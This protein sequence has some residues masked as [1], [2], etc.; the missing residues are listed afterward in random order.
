MQLRLWPSYIVQGTEPLTRSFHLSE[1]WRRYSFTILPPPDPWDACFPEIVLDATAEGATCL[2]AVQ[3]EPGAEATPFRP[4]EPLEA[5]LITDQPAN[6]FLE[7]ESLKLHLGLYA[8]APTDVGR[9]ELRLVDYRGAKV[10]SQPIIVRRIPAGRHQRVLRPALRRTGAFRAELWQGDTLLEEAIL[11]VAPEPR[12]DVTLQTTN[13]GAHF[14]I[15][16][17]HSR[18][19]R[20]LGIRW[21]RFHDCCTATWWTS[22]EPERGTFVFD[23]GPVKS[24]AAE[25]C[26]ALGVLSWSVPAWASEG[27]EDSQFPFRLED[28]AR[29]VEATVRHYKPWIKHWE[30]WNEAGGGPSPDRYADLLR[31]SHE[32]IKRADPEASVVALVPSPTRRRGTSA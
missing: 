23:D 25:G 29:Y 31:V 2:D 26:Q 16:R 20:R 14:V 8:Q 17:E 4:F 7:R 12:T 11:A 6:L 22:V 28:W 30:V 10:L 13:V 24:L 32:A 1:N 27:E 5:G 21:A 9:L 18:V 3:I 19:M 15:N